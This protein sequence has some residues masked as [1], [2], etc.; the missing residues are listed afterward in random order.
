MMRRK[1]GI[2]LV[3]CDFGLT[4]S[5]EEEDYGFYQCGTP[6]YMSPEV[7]ALKEG[8]KLTPS[9]DIF[10]VGVILHVLLMGRYLFEGTN[11]AQIFKANKEMNYNLSLPQY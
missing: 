8:E 10:S 7:L 4:V 9:S 11:Q 3:I 2:E 5:A 6:G 1:G